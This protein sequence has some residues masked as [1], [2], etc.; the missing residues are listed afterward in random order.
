LETPQTFGDVEGFISMLLAAC[1]DEEM[2]GTL[3]TLL[4]QPDDRRRATVHRLLERLRERQAPKALIEAIACLL[5]DVAAE[6]A[7]EAIFRCARKGSSAS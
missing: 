5:D 1:E 3:Q 7:Y 2:N 6:K 4:S